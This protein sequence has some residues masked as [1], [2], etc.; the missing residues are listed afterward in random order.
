MYEVR[1]IWETYTQGLCMMT[2]VSYL[3]PLKLKH[4]NPNRRLL[5]RTGIDPAEGTWTFS[6]GKRGSKSAN[7]GKAQK[8]KQG[9]GHR[10]RSYPVGGPL[11]RPVAKLA[12][13]LGLRSGGA[14]REGSTP[15]GPITAEV[16][17]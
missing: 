7:S 1:T 3:I 17:G 9:T 5:K 10:R 2:L 15:S 11:L 14:I 13:A 6:G 4:R 8:A 12:D 16:T